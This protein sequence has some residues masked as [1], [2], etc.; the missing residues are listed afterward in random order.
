VTKSDALHWLARHI[1]FTSF[2]SVVVHE[3]ETWWQKV[4]VAEPESVTRQPHRNFLQ[5]DADFYKGRLFLIVLPDRIVWIWQAVEKPDSES[6][7]VATLGPFEET[8]TEISKLFERWFP[9]SPPASRLALGLELVQPVDSVIEGYK[10]LQPYLTSLTLDISE[11]SDFMYRINRPRLSRVSTVKGL[12][13][14]RL[15]LWQV[16]QPTTLSLAIESSKTPKPP[17]VVSSS[18]RPFCRLEL[19]INTAQDFQGE[20]LPEHMAEVFRELV[21]LASEIAGRGDVK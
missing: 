19:D 6:R 21:E 11:S 2:P 20:I 3:A 9:I 12:K 5:L 15:S 18:V 17:L 16:A 8:V 4:V 7:D 14:N 1:R 10:A 13:I